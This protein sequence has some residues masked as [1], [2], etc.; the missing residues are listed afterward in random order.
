MKMAAIAASAGYNVDVLE[1]DRSG[2]RAKAGEESR[3]RY[4]RLSLKA[5]YGLLAIIALPIFLCFEAVRLLTVSYD[6][7]QPRNLD[8]LFP[9]L[10]I[11]RLRGFK[12]VY[13]LADFYAESY[14]SGVP[15]IRSIVRFTESSLARHV[16]AV[17]LAG[18]GQIEQIGSTNLPRTSMVFYNV[19]YDGVGVESVAAIAAP[20][21]PGSPVRLLY[22]GSLTPDRAEL[23]SNVERAIRGLAVRL[24]IG[25]FGEREGEVAK[26]ASTNSQVDFLGR[27]RHEEVMALTRAC[28]ISLLP[29][30]PR[31][32]NNRVGMPN[33]LFEAMAQGKPVMAQVGTL[34]GT[35]VEQF[36]FGFLTD[37]SEEEKVRETLSSVLNYSRAELSSMGARGRQVFESRFLPEAIASQYLTI[38]S[39]VLNLH[40]T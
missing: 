18:P 34:M 9:A 27:L 29:Y 28:D 10:V 40:E 15:V 11:S 35:M 19:P 17:V 12:V 36:R 25:G 30:N 16:N 33:K 3:V 23:L 20:D 2:A 8:A 38:L 6:L 5:P 14:A 39:N 21:A 26:M 22:A 31:L 37:F 4:V 7:V 24:V 32:R 13:D 1:W